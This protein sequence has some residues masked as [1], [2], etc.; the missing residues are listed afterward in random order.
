[1]NIRAYS[2]EQ[3][4]NKL[5]GGNQ[6]KVVVGKWLASHPRVLIMDEPT[7]GIDV[8]AKAEIHRMMS[9]LAQQGLAI[10]MISSELP[11]IMG[12]SDRIIVMREGKVVAEFERDRATQ[13]SVAA[14][15]MSDA[16]LEGV[17]VP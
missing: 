11:E 9:E 13:E 17:K 15:M 6:Q 16:T 1:L 8:G 10:L 5:S 2:I 7:R 3:I 12:M 14:A 4:V